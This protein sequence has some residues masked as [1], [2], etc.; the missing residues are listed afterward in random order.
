MTIVC[1]LQVLKMDWRQSKMHARKTITPSL[2]NGRY[3]VFVS[4]NISDAVCQFA[5]KQK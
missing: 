3:Q 2:K 5:Q 4:N 1:A